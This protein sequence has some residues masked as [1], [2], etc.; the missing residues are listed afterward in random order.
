[1]RHPLSIERLS[2]HLFWDADP[3][4]V[5]PEA[6]AGF[7]I[8]RIMDRGTMADVE[9]AWAAYGPDRVR[10]TLLRARSL[11]K[12]TIAFFAAQFGLTPSDFRAH[13]ERGEGWDA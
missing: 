1:M 6:H 2:P 10:E 13:R 9:A 4:Q 7:L 8:P 3:V 5:D 11:H 12:K